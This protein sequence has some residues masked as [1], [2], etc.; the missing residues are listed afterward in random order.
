MKVG[1]FRFVTAIAG[2]LLQTGCMSKT[3]G[4]EGGCSSA[5]RQ[6]NMLRAGRLDDCGTGS[7][8]GS[9]VG[10]GTSTDTGTTTTA[11]TDTG[12]TTDT[13]TSTDNGVSQG[14]AVGTGGNPFAP[15][16]PLAG[17]DPNH[18]FASLVQKF[19]S[20]A[21]VPASVWAAIKEYLNGGG[22]IGGN[23]GGVIEREAALVVSA[24]G[25]DNEQ[26]PAAQLGGGPHV[27]LYMLSGQVGSTVPTEAAS[28][29]AY[30][31][32]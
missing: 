18:F 8:T 32:E 17:L 21:D 11:G 12:T 4:L 3:P 22:G 23:G 24:G 31:Q 30:H 2:L 1:T 20:L 10:W 29:Y 26:D 15:G 7:T 9:G 14:T 25:A 13:G 5:A 27:K 19:G 28:F 16:G 6:A